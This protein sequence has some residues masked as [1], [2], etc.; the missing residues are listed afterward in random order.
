MGKDTQWIELSHVIK[1]EQRGRN[2]LSKPHKSTVTLVT[3]RHD[4]QT[5]SNISAGNCKGHF[6][7]SQ[8]G[9]FPLL[10]VILLSLANTVPTAALHRHD[11][12]IDLLISLFKMSNY[13]FK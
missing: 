8:A 7:Q 12:D 2:N 9:L 11:I 5:A 13:S 1:A 4:H 3:L 10:T 6:E